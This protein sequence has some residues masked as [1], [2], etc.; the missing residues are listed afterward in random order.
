MT[1]SKIEIGT[2]VRHP[3]R[4]AWGP[5]K[6]LS[7]GGG[8]QITVYFRDLEEEKANDAVKTIS[9]TVVGLEVADQQSDFM[10]DNLPVFDNG[11]FKGLRKPRLSLDQAIRT[12]VDK[13]PGA[14]GDSKYVEEER[15]PIVDAHQMWMDG[16]ADGHGTELLDEGKI[17]EAR[18][19]LLKI[20]AKL[21]LLRPHERTAFKRGLE[22]DDTA[23]PFMRALFAVTAD[24]EPARA[25]YQPLID[26]VELMVEQ[27]QGPRTTNWSVLTQFPFIACPESHMEFKPPALQKCAAR[28]N[29]DVHYSAAPNWWTYDRLL[30]LSKILLA[31]LEPLGA[32]DFIDV[33]SFIEVIAAA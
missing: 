11:K 2:I 27:E 33:H 18:R 21:N 6:T 31:R 4:P 15:Q 5:G 24:V 7:V 22:D 12:F 10:L 3:K 9:T 19:R 29:F 13:R 1:E 14:F 30:E 16:L 17:A 25:S 23:E 26:A 20:D 32:K 28:L 8:G